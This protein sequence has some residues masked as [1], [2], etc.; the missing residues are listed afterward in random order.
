MRHT[1][2]WLVLGTALFMAFQAFLAQQERTRFVASSGVV[3]LKRAPDGHYHWPGSVNG[4]AVDFLV[5]TGATRTALP[6]DIADRAG[7]RKVG[8]SRSSTAGGDVVVT[9]VVADVT[10]Q[11]GLQVQRLR[12]G[13]MPRLDTA[14]LGMDVLGKLNVTQSQGEMRISSSSSSSS[15]SNKP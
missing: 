14:L 11:G 3:T 8:M 6:P 7:L 10:L 9:D 4:V 5:D 2:V 12:V 1:I 13:V 15:S